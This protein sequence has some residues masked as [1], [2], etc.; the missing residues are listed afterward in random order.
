M[1]SFD[2]QWCGC[3]RRPA[4]PYA[5]VPIIS[6]ILRADSAFLTAIFAFHFRLVIRAGWAFFT[7]GSRESRSIWK[8]RTFPNFHSSTSDNVG[9]YSFVDEIYSATFFIDLLVKRSIVSTLYIHIVSTLYIYIY[10]YH[11]KCESTFDTLSSLAANQ[12]D[13]TVSVAHPPCM[14]KKKKFYINI[15]LSIY[16]NIYIYIF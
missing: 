5:T 15:S 1:D 10:I 14:M 8:S 2:H 13:N 6:F 11:I 16:I 7:S 12:G 9:R 3:R 4:S